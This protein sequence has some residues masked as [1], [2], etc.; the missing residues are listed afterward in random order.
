VDGHVQAFPYGRP[1]LCL[2]V[3]AERVVY[4]YRRE[5]FHELATR[6]ALT[7]TVSVPRLAAAL[8]NHEYGGNHV[9]SAST[10]RDACRCIHNGSLTRSGKS[11]G[12]VDQDAG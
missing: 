7:P 12:A 1:L 8:A 6:E 5:S 11:F 3:T 10:R 9:S 2:I 4:M